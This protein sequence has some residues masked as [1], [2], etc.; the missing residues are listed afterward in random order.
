M[1]NMC[2]IHPR[3]YYQLKSL[4]TSLDDRLSEEAIQRQL[5]ILWDYWYEYNDIDLDK[6]LNNEKE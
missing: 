2:R 1:S 5:G 6:E 4:L 3:I